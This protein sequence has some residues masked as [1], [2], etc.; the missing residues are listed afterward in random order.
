MII[1]SLS[2]IYVKNNIK[3]LWSTHMYQYILYY[4]ILMLFYIHVCTNIFIY[5]L[6]YA[7]LSYL[8]NI[9]I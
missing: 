9:L 5:V 1:L 2:K 8:Q 3:A 7:I 6:T 4:I